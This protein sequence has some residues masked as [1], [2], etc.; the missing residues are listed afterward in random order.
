M[1]LDLLDIMCIEVCLRNISAGPTLKVRA[2][3][4]LTTLESKAH[5]GSATSALM[6]VKRWSRRRVQNDDFIKSRDVLIYRAKRTR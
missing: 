2:K 5:P 6:G 3:N 4:V 1:S